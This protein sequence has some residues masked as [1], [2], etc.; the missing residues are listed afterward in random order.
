VN[1][2]VSA[3]ADIIEYVSL[4]IEDESSTLGIKRMSIDT[5]EDG[6]SA[7]LEESTKSP[8]LLIQFYEW[9]TDVPAIGTGLLHYDLRAKVIDQAGEVIAQ[10]NATGKDPMINPDPDSVASGVT[11]RW[12]QKVKGDALGKVL[13]SPDIINAINGL[14][15][16][17]S[18]TNAPAISQDDEPAVPEAETPRNS[19]TTEQFL[20]MKNAGLNDAQILAACETSN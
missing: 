15:S 7:A 9:K 18:K 19:C 8:V 11:G 1:G 4:L 14:S 5:A 13:L 17:Q 12:Y 3:S 6:L 2:G 20:S 10:K 16:T